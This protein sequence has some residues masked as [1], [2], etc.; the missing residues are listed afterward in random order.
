MKTVFSHSANKLLITFL[1]GFTLS[2][3]CPSGVWE[4][5]FG[6]VYQLMTLPIEEPDGSQSSSFQTVGTVDTMDMGCGVWEIRIPTATE[7]PADHDQFNLIWVAENP[8]PNPA[9]QCCSA[10]VFKGDSAGSYCNLLTGAYTNI[11]NK[12]TKSGSMYLQRLQ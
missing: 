10:L 3:C 9:D 4:D 7:M 11:G 6:S 5:N 1:V 2:A 8:N 12:C